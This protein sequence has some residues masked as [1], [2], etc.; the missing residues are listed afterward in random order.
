[1]SLCRL[2]SPPPP[3][4]HLSPISSTT[5]P[6]FCVRSSQPPVGSFTASSGTANKNVYSVVRKKRKKKE[7]RVHISDGG[8]PGWNFRSSQVS[9]R[10]V[11][12]TVRA[13][14]RAKF[15]FVV[16][17]LSS[18]SEKGRQW[19]PGWTNG[20]RETAERSVS[21]LPSVKSNTKQQHSCS[22]SDFQNKSVYYLYSELQKTI[23]PEQS[24][25]IYFNSLISDSA[26]T[27]IPIC[28]NFCFGH[29]FTFFPFRFMLEL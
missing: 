24:W 27:S 16:S 14:I 26:R 22:G 11:Q 17:V 6:P 25:H 5:Q 29:S 15:S 18:R 9:E 21:R 4:V 12:K 3:P 20:P 8:G 23:K 19:E 2:V 10:Y 13:K 1:M 28:W 7:K